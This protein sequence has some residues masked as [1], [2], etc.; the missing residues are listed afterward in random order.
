MR[1]AAVCALLC[2]ATLPG[3]SVAAAPARQA[4]PGGPVS[5]TV[6][7]GTDR[8]EPGDRLGYRITVRNLGDTDLP[9]TR[10][11]QRMPATASS[12]TADGGRVV[13][14]GTGERRAVWRSD[15]PAHA[16]RE[17]T[18]TAV[19]G[20]HPTPSATAAPGT[21]RAATTV[22][23]YLGGS[24]APSAC[25]GDTD[26]LPA[27][28]EE[29]GDGDDGWIWWTVVLVV[30]GLLA[31]GVLRAVRQRRGGAGGGRQRGAGGGRQRGPGGNSGRGPGGTG[32]GGR[33]ERS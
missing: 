23:V 14:R 9:A 24:G 27:T 3:P 17:F 16:V 30:G 11:E 22:C 10:T 4:P 6:T 28:R 13:R 15:L 26:D 20:E 7:D 8:A 21:L 25:S 12:V 33:A 1:T 18:A 5:V 2:A 32:S 31:S 29:D 19:L